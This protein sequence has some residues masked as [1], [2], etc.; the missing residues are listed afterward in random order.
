[1]GAEE[2]RNFTAIG[3]TTNLAARL[4]GVAR[5]GEV[6]VGPRTAESLPEARLEPLGPV[7]VKGKA[8]PV[9]VFRLL[10]TGGGSGL[11]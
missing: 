4:E 10:G 9:Q 7:E 1:V 5:P 11:R 6:V 3:D 8:E 2:V